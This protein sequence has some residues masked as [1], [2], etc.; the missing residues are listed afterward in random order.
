MSIDRADE[1]HVRG[2]EPDDAMVAFVDVAMPDH[3]RR[4]NEVA[5]LHLTS[6]PIDDGHRTLG[7]GGEADGSTGMP[8]RPGAVA[9]IE[10]GERRKQC[11][12][13][14]RLLSEC[15]MRH[16]QRA[17]LDVVDGHFADGT[18]QI[19]LDVAPMPDEWSVGRLRFDGRNALI[20]VPQRMQVARFK[21]RDERSPLS[22]CCG[23]SH[24]ERHQLF[25]SLASILDSSI[26]ICLMN[27]CGSTLSPL[28]K[29][30]STSTP[31]LPHSTGLSS[32]VI[33]RLPSFTA[34]SAGGTPFMPVTSVLPLRPAA[35]TAC[36]TPSATSSLAA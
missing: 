33:A 11:A 6:A 19:G 7:A 23:F 22:C 5:R 18:V 28:R 8:V 14:G 35:F 29:V 20:A 34:R 13:R 3:G 26:M 32:T 12:G 27:T 10:H 9:G 4:E 21:L 24:D 1:W 36:T 16:D 2:V 25:G 17:P 15:R 31:S 30:A